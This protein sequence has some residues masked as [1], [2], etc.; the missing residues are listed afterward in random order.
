MQETP[1]DASLS[2]SL[3]AAGG[4]ARQIVPRAQLEADVVALFEDQR[5]PLLRYLLSLGIPIPDGEEIVQEAFLALFQHLARG[6]PRHNLPGW[7]FRVA[8]NLGLK[9]ARRRKSSVHGGGE[10]MI[11]DPAPNPE[12]QAL[13]LQRQNRLMG[14]FR[15][16]PEQDRRCLALRAE[17]LRYREIAQVVEMSLGS[18]AASIARSLARLGRAADR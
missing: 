2:L 10:A 12:Q 11:A 14:V 15:V 5:A 17:G 16:L 18:V 8:H 1:H 6:G 4:S 7:M 9:R 3:S 13:D